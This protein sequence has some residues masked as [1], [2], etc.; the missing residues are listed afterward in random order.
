MTNL[1]N[2]IKSIVWGY[3]KKNI[4]FFETFFD[5]QTSA[6]KEKSTLSNCLRNFMKSEGI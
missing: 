6:I 3:S 4:P 1:L 2:Y 5:L